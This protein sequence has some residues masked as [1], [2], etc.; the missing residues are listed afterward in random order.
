MDWADLKNRELLRAAEDN[1]FD[2]FVTGDRSLVH[3]QN[4]RGQ[5]H[6]AIIT[7]ISNNWP[8]LKD[9]SSKILESIDG[10]TPGSFCLVDCGTFPHKTTDTKQVH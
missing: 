6:L 2:I 10:A 1:G 9:N 4:L 5:R 7:L 8:I 3:E